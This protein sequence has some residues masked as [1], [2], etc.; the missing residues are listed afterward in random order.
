MRL[1]PAV[2]A[3]L[4]AWTAANDRAR[5]EYRAHPTATTRSAPCR[6]CGKRTYADSGICARCQGKP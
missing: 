5:A 6:H 1:T 2:A 3:Q 4:A